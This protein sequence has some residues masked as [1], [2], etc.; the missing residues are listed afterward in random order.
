MISRQNTQK[1]IVGNVQI[2]HQNKVIVQSM[3][4]TKTS[5]VN[6]TIQQIR[7]LVNAGAQLVRVAILD[8]IDANA[9]KKIVEKAPC[10]IIADIHYNHKLAMLAIKNGAAKIRINPAN[11]NQ[12][13]LKEI[14]SCAKKYNTVIRIGINQGSKL[15]NKN[16][17]T[18]KSMINCALK[19]IKLFES[20]HFYKIIV[21]LKSSDPLLTTNLY[22]LASHKI[23][24]PLH[25]G[26]TEAGT[27]EN[28]IIK[29]SIGLAPLL[30]KGIGDT[31]RISISGD[32]IDEPRIARK[33]LHSLHLCNDTIDIIACPTCG[34]LQWNMSDLLKQVE[35]YTKNLKH[36]MSIAIMGCAVNGIGEC[37]HAD[38]GIY[39][40]K[41][42]LFLYKKRH[43]LKKIPIHK[44]FVEIKQL[45]HDFQA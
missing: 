30:S 8:E 34:R 1:I 39:G 2:G 6:A 29:S 42:Q 25:L 18:A 28:A 32:P 23:K 38:I 44:G 14:V 35:N 3:T 27:K 40:N 19:F 9:L 16:F 22:E 31:I 26:V 4:N 15:N 41:E 21:S 24:Y 10:P 37:E 45:I 5:D 36:S 11:I 20:W 33:I 12:K 7:K 17:T 43:L 13:L